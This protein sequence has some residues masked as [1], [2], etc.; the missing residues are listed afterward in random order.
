M[1]HIVGKMLL[2]GMNISVSSSLM[3][4]SIIHR[5]K[6][7]KVIHRY[8]QGDIKYKDLNGDGLIDAND[9]KVIGKGTFP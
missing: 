3:M 1:A 9:E 7:V 5:S 8:V 6:M 2:G 4:R